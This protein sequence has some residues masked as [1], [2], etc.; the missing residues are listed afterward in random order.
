MSP[1]DLPVWSRGAAVLLVLIAAWYAP[2]SDALVTLAGHSS[3]ALGAGVVATSL[4]LG[5]R[6]PLD[7]W[8]QQPERER[9]SLPFALLL[10]VVM[11]GLIVMSRSS[12]IPGYLAEFDRGLLVAI[13][14]GGTAW[15]LGWGKIRQRAFLG[16][17]GVAAAV[18]LVP[19]IAKI[20]AATLEQGGLPPVELGT[21]FQ[22]GVF[23]LVAGAAGALVTQELAFR[24]VMIGQAGDAGLALVLIS[25][26][27]FGAWL[28]V[29]PDP[30]G[31]ALHAATLG[32]LQGVVLGSLYT[33]SRSLL[34]PA[35]YHGV[36]TAGLRAFDLASVPVEGTAS[37]N[38]YVMAGMAATGIV[39]AM[40][41]Y[42]VSR[43]S[44]F[45]GLLKRRHTTD[46]SSD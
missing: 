37:S 24:R 4:L 43:R 34:V 46:A 28:A 44:G 26:L 30:P 6:L 21:F 42:R 10:A 31:G 25:A 20:I 41:A 2:R 39:A 14:V 40:L 7:L 32:T 15:A 33:L 5:M 12:G 45:I 1:R 8:P 9:F 38:D 35:L 18:G 22:V 27:A 23:S 17:Y 3:L 29:A 11:G 16:W 13:V 19:L 36:S